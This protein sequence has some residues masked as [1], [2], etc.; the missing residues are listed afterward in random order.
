VGYHAFISYSHRADEALAGAIQR[1]LHKMARG[2]YQL[3][4]LSVFRDKTSLAA[5]P[6]LWPTIQTALAKST[7]FLLI[8][9]RESAQSHWVQREVEWWL[10]HRSADKLL[11][12][13]SAGELTWDDATRDFDWR[14][15]DAV[16]QVLAKRFAAEPFFVDLRWARSEHNLTLSNLRFRDAVLDLAAPLHGVAKEELDGEDL[17]QF[18]RTK[19]L[20]RLA[21]GALALLTVIAT[22][23]GLIAWQQRNIAIAETRRALQQ[24][25]EAKAQRDEAVRQRNLSEAR[26]LFTEAQAA[27]NDSE[28]AILLALESLRQT[29]LPEVEALLRGLLALRPSQPVAY[30]LPP[31]RTTELFKLAFSPLGTHLAAMSNTGGTRIVSLE[32]TEVAIGVPQE[33]VS[34][35]AFSRDGRTVATLGF[36]GLLISSPEIGKPVKLPIAHNDIHS[37]SLS[38]DGRYLAAG[39]ATPYLQTRSNGHSVFELPHGREVARVKDP[40]GR[41]VVLSADGGLLATLDSRG[42][43]QLWRQED[44]FMTPSAERQDVVD[45][46]FSGPSNRL[47]VVRLEDGRLLRLRAPDGQP[48]HATDI[49][50]A[51]LF[52]SCPE[53]E[54]IAVLRGNKMEVLDGDGKSLTTFAIDAEAT[55]VSLLDHG[56]RV[57]VQWRRGSTLFDAVTGREL[58]RIRGKTHA[59]SP[60]GR[61]VALIEG[62]DSGRSIAVFRVDGTGEP[63]W[64]QHDDAI[65]DLAFSTSGQF[66]S[67]A[68]EDGTARVWRVSDGGE[69]A[70]QRHPGPVG[71][72]RIS[73]DGRQV[74]SAGGG[75]VM[76]WD[77]P[78]GSVRSTVPFAHAGRYFQLEGTCRT[79]PADL[80]VALEG[81]TA[82]SAAI[83]HRGKGLVVVSDVSAGRELARVEHPPEPDSMSQPD[84]LRVALSPNGVFLASVNAGNG[85]RVWDVRSAR[86]VARFPS[87]GDIFSAVAVGND[88]S[89]AAFR[90]VNKTEL[91]IYGAPNS[92]TRRLD[93]SAGFSAGAQV[94]LS[95]NGQHLAI[96]D[97]RFVT[98]LDAGTTRILTRIEHPSLVN[99][100]AFSPDGQ[101]VATG[102]ADGAVRTWRWRLEDLQN[103]ACA[104]VS[105][106]L[107]SK[108]WEQYLPGQAPHMTCQVPVPK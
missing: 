71:A 9:N 32:G 33:G 78:T 10:E 48:L 20:S 2:W 24:E 57:A 104:H 92:G 28:L 50:D 46:A 88:G 64:L 30:K 98:I 107:T 82:T 17:R 99:A 3:R 29:P 101:S 100:V 91:H 4:A 41:R 39:Y 36:S 106:N 105:R 47:L 62:E 8:A 73:A 77:V 34:R 94:S 80:S 7:Y 37:I 90:R 95:R 60:D 86:E 15:T 23:A 35:I 45:L 26:R 89:V 56:R 72:V 61:R 1:A 74:L 81:T 76:L 67:S 18:K 51:L 6:A 79:S 13:L 83:V 55:G 12:I 21:I 84:Y 63:S 27:E 14:R 19:R 70:R 16:P 108:E 68:S 44:E 69:I 38:D 22:G 85:G 93:E 102:A 49:A 97:G 31:A 40:A 58:A 42:R 53:S 96:A 25:A 65:C 5:N 11:I 54:R 59:W 52:A 66:L 75:K 43:L 103:A 87:V